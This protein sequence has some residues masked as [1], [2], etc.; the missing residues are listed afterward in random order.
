MASLAASQDALVSDF[1]AFSGCTDA[2]Q[3]TQYLSQCHGN[4]QDAVQ[5]FMAAGGSS[6]ITSSTNGEVGSNTSSSSNGHDSP[7][8]R[9][10]DPVKRQRLV[11]GPVYAGQPRRAGSNRETFR[12]FR[13]EAQQ[14]RRNRTSSANNRGGRADVAD[15]T[16][17][18]KSLQTMF[19]PPIDIMFQGDF[20]MAKAAARSGGR[21][22]LV[23]IQKNDVFQCHALNRDVWKDD[24]AKAIITDSLVFWFDTVENGPGS[25]FATLYKVNTYPHV[26]LI[27]PRTGEQAKIILSGGLLTPR[28]FVE[29][30]Q[31]Y[32]QRNAITPFD[33]GST[34]SSS[35][36]SASSV[37]SVSSRQS[38]MVSLPRT[39][40]T[41][42]STGRK[43]EEED[44][45][46]ALQA[47][48]A[49]S[50][51]DS[52]TKMSST[53]NSAHSSE[54]SAPAPP[55]PPSIQDYGTPPLEP[56]AATDSNETTRLRLRLSNGKQ[57]VRKFR[58]DDTVRG[59]FAVV[60]Q[61]L[62][63]EGDADISS[64]NFE[65]RAGYPPKVLSDDTKQTL[66][67]ASLENAQVAVRLLP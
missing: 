12:S 11:A 30:V 6:S 44:E 8:I 56:D 21:W 64:K 62:D 24:H 20:E 39:S 58:K 45:D 66:Q 2:N 31:D 59:L 22:L 18:Q 54:P 43:R 33:T 36:S 17:K 32:V 14:A 55:V 48:L 9:A 61:L 4:L 26:A 49:A 50:L 28:D 67:G 41:S 23:N 13:A 10:P 7:Q 3:A 52:D 42:T 46:A 1:M 38:S 60:R 25:H 35:S 16:P 65:L 63:M 53:A 27:D 34:S 19:A 57:V 40:S 51:M 29:R 37:S 47:A 5:L 15:L